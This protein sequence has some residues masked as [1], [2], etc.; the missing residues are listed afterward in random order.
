MPTVYL[1]TSIS[2]G[3]FV[4]TCLQMSSLRFLL[5]IPFLSIDRIQNWTFNMKTKLQ[6]A[7]LACFFKDIYLSDLLLFFP[8]LHAIFTQ[9]LQLSCQNNQLP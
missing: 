3:R 5:Q 4:E 9:L 7:D 8:S 6:R 1:T 2:V